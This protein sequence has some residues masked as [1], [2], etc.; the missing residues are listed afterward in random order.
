VNTVSN[1]TYVDR[2]QNLIELGRFFDVAAVFQSKTGKTANMPVC[3]IDQAW[4]DLMVNPSAYADFTDSAV[5]S[6]VD[7]LENKGEGII[8][9]VDIYHE[10]FGAL[11]AVWFVSP[12]EFFDSELYDRYQRTRVLEMSWDCAPRFPK[13]DPPKKQ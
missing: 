5:G 8:E 13:V 1:S 3:I 12:L 7:H 10:K 4:H 6:S 9:W 11:P 2:T